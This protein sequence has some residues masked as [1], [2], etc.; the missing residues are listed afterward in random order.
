MEK[1][2]NLDSHIAT[3]WI[4]NLVRLPLLQ[5]AEI[6]ITWTV[7]APTYQ[8]RRII[9]PWNVQVLTEQRRASGKEDMDILEQEIWNKLQRN[10]CFL[11][12]F[13]YKPKRESSFCEPCVD[14]KQSNCHFQRQEEKGLMNSLA[15]FAVMYVEILR[16]SHLV[17]QNISKLLSMISQDLFGFILWNT[18]V[19]FLKSLLNG[20]KTQCYEN[21][22]HFSTL[23]T[24]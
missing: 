24:N 20:G 14:G 21:F 5:N 15:S 22:K 7:L 12:R 2:S 11:D 10:N 17:E 9:Q 3:S 4:I 8:W 13:D 23:Q 16:Q 18:K 1:A 19:K 6:C